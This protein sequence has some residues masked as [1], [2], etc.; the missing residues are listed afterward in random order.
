MKI[1]NH[2]LEGVQRLPYPAGPEMLVRRFGIAHFTAGATAKSSWEFWKSGDAAGAE[3]HVLIDRDGTIYQVRAFN[4]KAD[5]AG[6]SKWHDQRATYEWLN[7][8][9]IG[10]EFA[11]A[12]KDEPGK[13]AFDW[14]RA[15]AP[16]FQSAKA[17]HKNGGPIQEWECYPEAQIQSGILV[18]QAITS[19]Y[20]L[21]DVV[22]HDDI[23][24]AR[25]DDPGPLF[26]MQRLREACG[27]KGMPR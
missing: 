24:P 25:K 9:S 14:A 8:C 15:H 18:F 6:R 3:A 23:A 1:I 12:G 20:H 7:S 2:W 5:H 10:V 13:D 22:G 21:D 16:G 4:Q 17:R 26:P 19:F 27:F 11:N